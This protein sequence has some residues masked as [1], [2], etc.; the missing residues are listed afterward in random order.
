MSPADEQPFLDAILARYP[1]DGPRLVYADWLD[2]NGDP[3][4][5]ELVR[6]QLALARITD[7]DPRRTELADR[8]AELHETVAD[9]WTARLGGLAAG[10]EFR[11]GV[12]DAVTVG[13]D[14]FL[15]HGADLFRLAPVVRRVRLTDAG[16]VMDRL[17]QCATLSRV[18][19]LDLFGN[20]LGT[21]GVEQLVQSPYLGGLDAL[22]LGFNGLDGAAVRALARASTLPNLKELAL[23]DNRHI[24]G[25]A[26]RLLADSPFLA[27][28]RALDLSGNDVTDAGIRALVESRSL[29]R[30]AGLRLADNPIGDAGVSV[31]VGSALFRRVLAR[32]PHLDLRGTGIGPNGAAA[33]ARW[34][35]AAGATVLDLTRNDLGDAGVREVLG[36]PH[37]AGLRVL[38]LAQNQITDA[39]AAALATALPRFTR[40]RRLDVCGNRL[41]RRGIDLLMAARATRPL[42]IDADGNIHAVPPVTVGDVVAGVLDGVADLRRRITHPTARRG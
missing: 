8:Q 28:L 37:L 39:G 38:R 5:A 21:G 31:L 15:A 6:V 17:A 36:G 14:T 22:D 4:R 11:R 24:T 30:L 13:G 19:E 18:R 2:E 25:D 27:G 42:E 26:V 34:P 35:D 41:T 20:D 3:D 33:L 16:R 7:D 32:E 40:L 10:V 12:P 29:V 9:A 23:N 1:D